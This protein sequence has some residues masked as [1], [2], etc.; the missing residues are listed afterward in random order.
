MKLDWIGPFHL[1]AALVVVATPLFQGCETTRSTH[2]DSN[3]VLSAAVPIY[4]LV[5]KVDSLAAFLFGMAYAL[6]PA[7]IYQTQLA[8]HV[9]SHFS[10]A[11]ISSSSQS[12]VTPEKYTANKSFGVISLSRSQNS[13]IRDIGI[14]SR[15]SKPTKSSNSVWRS[16]KGLHKLCSAM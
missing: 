6:N 11:L 13:L 1:M 3:A 8:F 9:L 7:V 10:N 5:R 15:S 16:C 2:G 14:L 4:L 12:H